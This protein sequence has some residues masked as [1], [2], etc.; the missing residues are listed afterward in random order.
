MAGKDANIEAAAET[1]NWAQC[2]APAAPQKLLKHLRILGRLQQ[3]NP[4]HRSWFIRR[5]QQT[6]LT[7]E[8]KHYKLNAESECFLLLLHRP[9][10]NFYAHHQVSNNQTTILTFDHHY[11]N[12]QYFDHHYFDCHPY[13]SFGSCGVSL[14]IITGRMPRSGNLAVLFLLSSQKSTF[15]PLE[16]KL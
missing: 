4:I 12:C 7:E 8:S 16:E 11:F 10:M 13:S 2:T 14:H 3:R 1:S 5:R 15:C 6:P 9:E